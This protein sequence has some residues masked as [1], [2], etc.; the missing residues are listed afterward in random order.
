VAR[1]RGQA[2]VELLAVV[3]A[4]LAVGLVTWQLILVG[5]TA[6]VSAHAARAAARATLVGRDAAAAARSVLPAGLERGLEVERDGVRVP[7]PIVHHGWHG[8][9]KVAARASLEAVE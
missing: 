6:W 3:P 7:V 2:T 9:V 5:H 4:L 1:E 8:P